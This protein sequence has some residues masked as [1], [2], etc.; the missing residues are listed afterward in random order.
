MPDQKANGD[1]A[2]VEVRRPAIPNQFRAFLGM[3][4][5][6]AD[7]TAEDP[8]DSPLITGVMKIM[9]AADDNEMWTADDLMQLGGRDLADVE[10]GIQ[11]F[12]VR[13]SARADIDTP[14]VD[15]KGRKMFLLVR[16]VKLETGEEIVWNTSAPLLVAK[17]FWLSTRDMLPCEAVIRATDLGAGQA[18]LKLKPIPRR[19]VKA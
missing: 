13:R 9:E 6:E 3:M 2:N 14:F 18:V 17:L 7:A 16:S 1:D 15:S 19:A 4:E 5:L 10:M 8:S 12:T 11:S